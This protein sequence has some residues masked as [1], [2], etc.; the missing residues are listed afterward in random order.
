MF[1]ATDAGVFR[2]NQSATGLKE[3]NSQNPSL[4][5]LKQNY[6]NPFNSSTTISFDIKNSVN[7]SLTIYNLLGQKVK[8][9]VQQKLPAGKH[10]FNWDGKNQEG[11]EVGSGVYIYQWKIS[12][13][14]ADQIQ[15]KKML[16]IK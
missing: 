10:R 9:I 16:Y 4:F 1:A 11:E 6:P 12:S 15:S 2:T 13:K 3:I 8:T 7:T 14:V 5:I